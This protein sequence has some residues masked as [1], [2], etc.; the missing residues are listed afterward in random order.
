MQL[1]HMHDN[2]T[3]NTSIKYPPSGFN[4]F[5]IVDDERSRW[6]FISWRM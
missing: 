4:K 5:D 1:S 3:S 2:Q 6:S